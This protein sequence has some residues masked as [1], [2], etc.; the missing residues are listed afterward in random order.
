MIFARSRHLDCE[1]APVA[2]SARPV[3]AA[4][5]VPVWV[6]KIAQV[7]HT[8]VTFSR[9]RRIFNAR[10][11]T[12]YSDIVKLF[13]L[14]WRIAR[15]TDRGTV[16]NTRRPTIDGFAYAKSRACMHI[17]QA[18]LPGVVYMLH[19]RTRTQNTQDGIVEIPC[20]VDIARANHDM[21]KHSTLST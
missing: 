18:G 9:P 5:F 11:P 17:E 10:G 16:C 6:Q 2:Y 19:W 14:F 13:N 3:K 7:H 21:V 12:G 4:Y 8:H 15:K 20:L 1:V